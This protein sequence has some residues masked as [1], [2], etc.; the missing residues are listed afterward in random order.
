MLVP[1]KLGAGGVIGNG[2]QYMSW[3]ARDD[4]VG[5][6]YHALMTDTLHGPVNVVS[7]QPV[8][9]R[10]YTRVLGRV[11][12]RPTLAPLP[13]FAARLAFGE[14]AEA[15]FLASA[16]VEPAQLIHSG[17]VFRYPEL[18]TALQHLLGKSAAPPGRVEQPCG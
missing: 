17:Y 9:N 11:L 15:L 1:F 10:E 8:T 13:A 16:R 2:Q 12:R 4:V 6:V 14:M 3:I 7:P 5:A 18:A